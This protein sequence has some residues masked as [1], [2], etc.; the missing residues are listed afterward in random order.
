MGK[1]YI[2]TGGAGF[3]GSH[4]VDVLLQDPSVATVGVY[5]AMTYAGDERNLR[6][7]QAPRLVTRLGKDGD[8]CNIDRFAEFVR[9]IKPDGIFHLAAESHVDQSLLNPGK[10]QQTNEFGSRNVTNVALEYGIRLLYMSTDEVM[11]DSEQQGIFTEETPYKPSSPYSHSKMTEDCYIL[12][13]VYRS[14]LN[15]NPNMLVARPCNQVGPRQQW[16]KFIPRVIASAMEG[17][18]VKLYGD[19]LHERTW[20]NVRDCAMALKLLMQEG[21][22]GNAYIIAPSK[23]PRSITNRW[24]AEYILMLMGLAD[25][26]IEYIEDRP[27]HDRRYAMDASKFYELITCW[28]PKSLM[29]DILKETIAWY[30]KPENWQWLRACRAR[31]EE[32]R[33]KNYD[34]RKEHVIGTGSEAPRV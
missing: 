20:M 17:K 5:D 34:A 32:F 3:I 2:V 6:G 25:T 30:L 16:E 18:P 23:K 4:L 24:L 33:K 7:H 14:L 8:V 31:D 10:F 22:G 13:T 28:V 29:I 1:R 26:P 15:K 11:G 12:D 27:G 9:E 21:V 19:G